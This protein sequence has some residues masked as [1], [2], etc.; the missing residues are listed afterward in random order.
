MEKAVESSGICKRFGSIT[1]LKD[2]SFLI[3][4]NEIF[5]FIGPD[6]AGKTTTIRM[7][8]GIIA[9]TS[10]YAI[11]GGHRTGTEAEQIPGGVDPFGAVDF[12]P[13]HIQ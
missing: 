10:G 11:V 1:A 13:N 12:A 2:I 5:G 9:P 7:L 8:S 6:G 4:E 3:D